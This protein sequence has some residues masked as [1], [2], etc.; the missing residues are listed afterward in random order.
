MI[1]YDMIWWSCHTCEYIRHNW[2]CVVMSVSKVSA[3]SAI[4]NPKS[5]IL[6]PMLYYAILYYAIP[7]YSILYCTILCYTILCF[8]MLCYAILFLFYSLRDGGGAHPIE[9][10]DHVCVGGVHLVLARQLVRQ[11]VLHHW[12]GHLHEPAHE[13]VSIRYVWIMCIYRV[14]VIVYSTIH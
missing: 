12:D 2:V 6:H 9:L 11:D 14:C 5:C 13:R 7:Y 10:E 4:L 1:W 8:T 3:I